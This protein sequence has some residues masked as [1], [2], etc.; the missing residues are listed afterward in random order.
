MRVVLTTVLEAGVKINDRLVAKI[1]RGYLLLVGFT[2]GDDKE[3]VDKMVDKILSLRVF[4]DE[5]GQINISLQDVNG[6][7]LSVSQFTL[8]A[9]TSKGRRPSFVD[10][11]R[12]GEAE[13]L[14]DY[15]NQ[16]LELKH[17]K[18]QTGV[19]GSDMKVESVNDGPFTLLLDSKELFY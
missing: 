8:Y 6:S 4:P 5:H 14:Y 11:L 18:V 17:G 1:S 16:Q 9:N 2:D 13:P 7:I 12:P 19:F 10:A 15:F 3:T